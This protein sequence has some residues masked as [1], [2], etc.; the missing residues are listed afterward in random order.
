MIYLIH[1]EPKAAR[2][3][4]LREFGDDERDL[5]DQARLELE[6]FYLGDSTEREIILLHASDR[7]QLAVTHGRYFKSLEE[8]ARDPATH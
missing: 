4:A 1:Y 8:L 2:V 6:R 7:A 3:L 5:A